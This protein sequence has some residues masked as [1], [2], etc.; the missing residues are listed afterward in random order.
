MNGFEE[1]EKRE[2]LARQ[3]E[4][5]I[6][7]S[8][9]YKVVEDNGWAPEVGAYGARRIVVAPIGGTGHSPEVND[10]L[11]LTGQK[12]PKP[13]PDNSQPASGVTE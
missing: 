4:E 12:A 1:R 9:H 10:V 6:P 3:R 5:A 11:E 2:E 13:T 7:V 8:Q